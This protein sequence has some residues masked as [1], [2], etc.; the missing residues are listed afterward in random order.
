VSGKGIKSE[1]KKTVDALAAGEEIAA[2]KRD[3][4]KLGRDVYEFGW[5]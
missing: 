3:L 5:K 2:L 4:Y 1:A